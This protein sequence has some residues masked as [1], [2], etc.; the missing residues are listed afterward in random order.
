MIIRFLKRVFA[1]L[2]ALVVA[3]GLLFA[4]ILILLAGAGS[5]LQPVAKPVQAQS[6]LVLDLGFSLTDRPRDDSPAEILRNALRGELPATASL[7]EVMDGLDSARK[8]SRVHGLLITG[9]L[10]A[11]GSGGSFA[12]LREVR[13]AVRAFALEK[14]VWAYIDGDAL[15]DIYLK[16]AATE[17]ICNPYGSLDFRG[18]RAERLYLGDA[19]ERIG[20]DFQVEA[21]EEYK[22]AAEAFDKGAMS[23][24]ERE[25]LQDL[26]GDLWAVI[27]SDIAQ[28]RQLG[29]DALD[30][31]AERE[32]IL[33]GD[34]VIASGLADRQLDHDGLIELLAGETAYDKERESFRQADFFDYL[35]STVPALPGAG[36]LGSGNKVAILYVE[37]AIMDGKGGEETTG[38]D[39]LIGQLREVRRDDSVKAVVL[40]VNSP[41]GSATASFKIAREIARTHEQKPVVASMGGYATSAGYMISAVAGHIFAEPSTITGSIGTVIML[42]NIEAL[43]EKLSIRFDGVETHRFAGVYSPGRAKTE[44]EMRQLRALGEDFYQQ[45]LL[46]VAEHRGMDA[47]EVRDRAKGRVWS[48]L[49]ALDLGLVDELGGLMAAVQRSAD[50]A[51]IGNDFSVIERPRRLTIEERIQ[52]YLLSAGLSRYQGNPSA[53]GHLQQAWRDLQDEVRRLGQLDDPHGQ[54]LMLPYSL[55]IN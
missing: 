20:V 45:F 21:F 27:V 26:L 9:N 53:P 17:L 40:R 42:S 14:P 43:A 46:L 44:E 29:E 39:T 2:F 41:G 33:M 47:K 37:G 31:L 11:G 12:A 8:D 19:F 16:S 55:K 23:A 10:L 38:A 35:K 18:L 3:Y 25:Q 34:E 48:G 1:W 50:L 22:T 24:Q 54:Y 6:V 13:Q 36:L 5:L 52:K 49:A 15:R 51:G 4:F 32:L 7:R 30:A 28:A